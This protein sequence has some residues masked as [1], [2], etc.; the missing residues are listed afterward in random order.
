M[1]DRDSIDRHEAIE[2][3][4]RDHHDA[5]VQAKRLKDGSLGGESDDQVTDRD[6]ARDFLSF[7][8]AHASHHF[9]EEEEV[10]L[11]VYSR[12][13]PPTEHKLIR[14]MLDDHAWF[15]D[16]VADLRLLMDQEEFEEESLR[17]LLEEIG[18]RLQEHARMEEREL[19]EMLQETLSEEDLDDVK[20][21]SEQFRQ[22]RRLED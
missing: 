5:L 17:L 8:D 19:F 2:A 6:V 12:H 11:P 18:R 10:L 21:R 7:W 13:Q 14:T 16:V 15:R 9:R 1:N 4:S 22:D 20:K 3:L